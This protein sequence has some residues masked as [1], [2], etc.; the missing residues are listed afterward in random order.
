MNLGSDGWI[1]RQSVWLDFYEDER[2]FEIDLIR[3]ALNQTGTAIE[4][5]TGRNL[6]VPLDTSNSS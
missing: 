6:H 5:I 1:S 3:R 4:C 2:G